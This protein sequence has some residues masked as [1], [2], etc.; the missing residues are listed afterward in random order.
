MSDPSWS[1]QANRHKLHR[2]NTI[3]CFY[4]QHSSSAQCAKQRRVEAVHER[5]AL[6]LK[7]G[8]LLFACH[9]IRLKYIRSNN[10]SEAPQAHASFATRVFDRGVVCLILDTSLNH[11]MLKKCW[12]VLFFSLFFFKHH[13][14]LRCVR[15]FM[16]S[17]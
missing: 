14:S 6:K 9:I 2:V 12:G 4:Y 3:F 11:G 10:K 5:A 7:P 8:G 15:G 17:L 1:D 16:L 13:L